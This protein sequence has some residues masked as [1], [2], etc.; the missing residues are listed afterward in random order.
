LVRRRVAVI[1]AFGPPATFAARAAATAIPT[2]FLVPDDPVRL[3]LITSLAR[4]GGNLTGINVL[5][6]EVGAKR[7]ELL[8]LPAL[9]ADLVS[10]KV[11]VIAATGGGVSVRAAKAA[12]SGRA[13]AWSHGDHPACAPIPAY[14][15]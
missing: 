13:C 10:R 6:A 11:A 8:R 3:G 15:G 1:A 7:L 12:N 5:N 9:A 2:I 14:S 4:P